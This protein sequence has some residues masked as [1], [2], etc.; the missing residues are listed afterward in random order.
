MHWPYWAKNGCTEGRTQKN[1]GKVFKILTD[2]VLL[3][4]RLSFEKQ[5]APGLDS[6]AERFSGKSIHQLFE[7]EFPPFLREFIFADC[8]PL[9]NSSDEVLDN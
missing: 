6:D 7:N 9:V 8:C 4:R 3:R 2:L 5:L 1:H